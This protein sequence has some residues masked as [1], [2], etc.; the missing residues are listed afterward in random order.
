MNGAEA[1]GRHHD[2]D[3]ETDEAERDLRGNAAV[4]EARAQSARARDTG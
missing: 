1:D 2:D 3:V 4:V